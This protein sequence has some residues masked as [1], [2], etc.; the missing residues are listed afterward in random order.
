MTAPT[1]RKVPAAPVEAPNA[2]VVGA[3][4]SSAVTPRPLPPV[5]PYAARYP[6]LGAPELQALTDDIR[7]RGQHEP[8]VMLDG[9]LID[10][11][12]RWLACTRAG[13]E[14]KTREYDEATDGEVE[15]FI[16]S[17]NLHRRHLTAEQR[18]MIGAL[19]LARLVAAGKERR[20]ANLRQ[21]GAAPERV[22]LSSS[23]PSIAE[24]ARISGSS[25]GSIKSA[26]KVLRT[27]MPELVAAVTSGAVPVSTAAALAAAPPEVQ[28]AAVAAGPK[29]VIA[30]VR[31][32]PKAKAATIAVAENADAEVEASGAETTP[33]PAPPVSPLVLLPLEVP[34]ASGKAG[35]KRRRRR[36]VRSLLGMVLALSDDEQRAL[37]RE[38]RA[39]RRNDPRRWLP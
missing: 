4:D 38:L 10:G 22:N 15:N 6:L 20:A 18:A 35:S 5:H 30:V 21:G 29:A 1:A 23:G 31:A 26:V 11:R 16:D 24:A 12:N 25:P 28:R 34:D 32:L 3:A 2:L 33:Q 7:E 17:C 36:S 39:R 37:Q 27:G 9:V 14:P 19:I 8:I 13:V